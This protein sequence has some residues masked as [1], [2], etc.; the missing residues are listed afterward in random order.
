MCIAAFT[1]NPDSETPLVLAANRDEFFARPAAPM[2]WWPDTQVLAGRDLKGNGT[3]LGITRQGRFALIT[4]IRNPLLRRQGAPSRGDIVKNF[5]QSSAPAT[6]FVTALASIAAR[7]EG[8]NLICGSVAVAEREVWFLH[9]A[10]PAPRRLGAG[11]YALS[12]A[13][14][15]TDWPKVARVKQG[16]RHALAERDPPQRHERMLRLLRN[17]N[18]F[19]EQ[20]LP[21][22]GVP[23]EWERAL[24]TIFINRDSYGTRAS[25]VMT[26]NAQHV[27]ATELTYRPDASESDRHEF[28][29]DL[30]PN[31]HP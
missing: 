25:T 24:S 17:T 16:M 15:D 18:P 3:W 26:V 5:L 7:Y 29:F 23:R 9:S 13:S 27:T 21:D 28:G 19:P 11:L 22:T 10:E 6:A 1:W 20:H 14:L 4:N 8:F 30:L 2:H 31:E 12:N